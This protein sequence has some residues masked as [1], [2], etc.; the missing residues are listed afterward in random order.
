VNSVFEKFSDTRDKNLKFDTSSIEGLL[1]DYALAFTKAITGINT[2]AIEEAV[3][4]LKAARQKGKRV[5]A[6]GNGGSASISEHLC[7]D[8]TKGTW[9]KNL[10]PMRVHSLASNVAVITAVSNDLEYNAAFTAQVELYGESGDIL[11]AISSSGNSPNI[12]SAVKQAKIMGLKVIGLSGFEGGELSR[13]S[14]I[15]LYTPI[16]HYGVAEDSHQALM[17]VFAILL[18]A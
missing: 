18:N 2:H 9:K 12:I 5:Y 1:K 3:A 7:C 4:L 10:S 17:H 6:I 15:S 13:L 14:D 16:N 11:V 8:W